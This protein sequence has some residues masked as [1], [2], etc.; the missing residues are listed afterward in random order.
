MP[1]TDRACS[2]AGAARPRPGTR[3]LALQVLRC[4]ARPL[5]ASGFLCACA[6]KRAQNSAG[7]K[8]GRQEMNG[9]LGAPT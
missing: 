8:R 9:T 2:L 6:L 1:A 4:G 7:D 3:D 5:R